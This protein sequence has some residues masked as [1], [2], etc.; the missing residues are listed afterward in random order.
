MGLNPLQ[1]FFRQPKIYISLPSKGIYNS[2]GMIQG[3]VN[4]LPVYGMTGMDEIIMK[5]PD[6]LISGDSTVKV[7]Q[8]CVPAITNPWELSNLD[9]DTVLTAIRVATFGSDL[10]VT[11]TCTNCGTENEYTVDLNQYIEHYQS[12]EYHNQVKLKDLTVTIRPLNY[13]QTTEFSLK[14]FQIQQQLI[15]L[16]KLEDEAERKQLTSQFF[17]EL[18]LLRNEVFA[19]GIESVSIGTTVVTDPGHIKEWL[20]NTDRDVMDS[21]RAVVEENQ[22]VWSTPSR[23]VV[24]QNCNHESTL[25]VDLDQSSFFAGA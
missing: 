14:N 24:C 11:R 17:Q 7:I 15:Q 12:C 22:Q 3:D 18:A 25:S 6:A 9:T 5:T 4:H 13:Q 19:A 8:S 10:P 16:E 20:E 2:Q 1:Q 23:K 21:I